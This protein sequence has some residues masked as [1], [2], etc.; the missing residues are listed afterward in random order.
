MSKGK[1]H[2]SGVLE[3]HAE[4]GSTGAGRLGRVD[5]SCGVSNLKKKSQLA[6]VPAEVK[7]ICCN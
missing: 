7:L 5:F 2:L 1:P 4:I 6:Y 3:G